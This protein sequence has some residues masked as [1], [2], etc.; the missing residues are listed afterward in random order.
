MYETGYVCCE[1]DVRGCE[2][3]LF[4]PEVEVDQYGWEVNRVLET[5]DGATRRVC[6]CPEHAIGWREARKAYSEAVD[7]LLGGEDK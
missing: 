3:K 5:A 2:Q 4:V 1:C 7:E 6:L